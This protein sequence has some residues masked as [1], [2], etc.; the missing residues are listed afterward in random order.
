[1]GDW[2]MKKILSLFLFLTMCFLA[3]F[4][5]EGSE[6]GQE[7]NYMRRG[8]PS[9]MDAQYAADATSM[10]YL[11]LSNGRL[12]QY[13]TEGTL[14]PQLAESYEVSDD[15]CVYTFHLRE[16]LHYSNGEAIPAEDFVFAFRRMVD[17]VAAS[18]CAYI[19]QD[20]CHLKNVNEV[21]KGEL[22]LEELGVSAPDDRT[23]VITLEKP[24]PYIA[25][26]LAL[27][28]CAPCSRSFLMKCGNDYAASPETMLSSGPFIVDRYEPLALQVHYVKNPEYID[29]DRVSLSG[30]SIREASNMQQS[31]MCYESGEAD[32]IPVQ[33]EFA[34]LSRDD[35]NLLS[36][37]GGGSSYIV[38]NI[39]DCKAWQNRNIRIA[40]N[41]SINRKAI[42]SDLMYNSGVAVLP[43]IVPVNFAFD[44]NGEDYVKDPDR[45]KE[46][47]GYDVEKA[48]E[49]WE[50]GLKELSVSS[51]ELE[52]LLESS[53]AKYSEV[54]KD[55]LERALPGLTITPRLVTTTQ[56][57]DMSSKKDF[58]LAVYVWG[59]D[60]PDPY[61]FLETFESSSSIIPAK[62]KNEKYDELMIEASLETD[63]EKRLQLLH[64]AEDLLMLEDAGVIPVYSSGI[65]YIINEHIKDIGSNFSGSILEFTYTQKES[66]S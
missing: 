19:F 20:L 38:G 2:K 44:P 64:Q 5:C 36:H 21:N 41:L 58:E 42:V 35:P 32:V 12:F 57:I 10:Q 61:S 50:K 45:Y 54:L 62:Y 40:L 7:L 29:A 13:T 49:Y 6:E 55:Q 3:V 23:L 52:L 24:C 26:I 66:A 56:F 53:G 8:R 15:G 28:C 31:I 48:R 65:T 11:V 37:T 39:L 14:E 46:I 9:T 17:P 18:P 63:R 60:F 22:P 27:P 4:V 43:G 34:V 51:L 1:M 33:G 47:C 59:A 25:H 16:G 30:V